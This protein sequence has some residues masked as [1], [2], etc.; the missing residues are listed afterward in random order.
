M[1]IK[2]KL[3]AISLVIFVSSIQAAEV[4]LSCKG[5]QGS[6]IDT[7]YKDPTK[8]SVGPDSYMGVEIR[9]TFPD[10]EAGG[11]LEQDGLKVEWGQTSPF[12][13]NWTETAIPVN[14]TRKWMSF[15]QPHET[16]TRLYSL[17]FPSALPSH[18]EVYLAY[19]EH[20]TDLLQTGLPEIK[21]F[22][23]TCSAI[24]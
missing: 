13:A 18:Q 21:Q 1:R 16:V 8:W 9:F 24:Q 3:A 19:T 5:M 15:I 4:K 10:E 23:A 14:M 2:T 20:Q 7:D 17:Y 6:R 22:Q 11:S 12:S